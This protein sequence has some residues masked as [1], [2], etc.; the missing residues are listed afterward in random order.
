MFVNRTNYR[1]CIQFMAIKKLPDISYAGSHLILI[2]F[3]L[4]PNCFLKSKPDITFLF[5]YPILALSLEFHHMCINTILFQ[6]HIGIPLFRHG[7][8]RENNDLIRSRSGTHTVGDNHKS[9]IADIQKCF[10]SFQIHIENANLK[11]KRIASTVRS[12]WKSNVRMFAR[13]RSGN[14][15]LCP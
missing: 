13:L 5:H 2:F 8:V 7:T 4:S 11:M 15:L 10:L 14:M 3:L 6:K 12:P 1:A 9:T